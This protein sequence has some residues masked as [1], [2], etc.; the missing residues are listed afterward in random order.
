MRKYL[1]TGLAM[2]APA[3]ANA[4]TPTP[5]IIFTPNSFAIPNFTSAQIFENFEGGGMNNTQYNPGSQQNAASVNAGFTQTVSGDVPIFSGTVPGES[6]NP[7]GGGD[8]YLAIQNGSFTVNFGSAGVQ[9]LSFI[10][11]SLDSYNTLTL[12]F[13]NG[14][15]STFAGTQI[16]GQS[17]VGPFNS[18]VNGRVSF[19]LGGQSS[20]TRAAFGSM[21]QGFV[22]FEIDE[23]AAAV[24]E[25]ATW[26]LMI[27]GFGLIGSQLRATRR[28][29][30]VTFA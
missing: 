4:Q 16:I 8:K 28:R 15:S 13:A 5:T 22:A 17:G 29:T 7:D 26:A 25:P 2:L 11:G 14:T 1:L 6:T 3:A 21:Q 19:D 24:P 30:K 23:L 10:F 20:I 27:L 12:S 18:N 9:F